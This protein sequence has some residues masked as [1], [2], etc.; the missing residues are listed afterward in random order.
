[1]EAA[2]W[3]YAVTARNWG[4]DW[5]KQVS[6][7]SLKFRSR[8]KKLLNMDRIPELTPW[9]Q[10]GKNKW[11][12]YDR[13]GE[14]FGSEDSFSTKHVFLMGIGLDLVN[15]GLKHSEVVFFLRHVRPKLEAAF[16]EIHMRPGAIAP[17]SGSNRQL[18]RFDNDASS[19]PIWLDRRKN[20]IADW[21]AWILIQRYEAKEIYTRFEELSQG[22]SIPLF[23]EPEFYFGLEAV[24]ER[25]FKHL[26]D[27]RHLLLIEIADLALTIPKYLAEAPEVRRGRPRGTVKKTKAAKRTPGSRKK[28]SS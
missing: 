14:G 27:F 10:P 17:V 13:A 4:A 26:P 19:E 1:M 5:D 15:E 12:F 25:M 21:T 20:P 6:Q 24:K 22:R 18:Y 2:L 28:G 11:A 9:G 7:V 16:D 23:I 8:I 3:R